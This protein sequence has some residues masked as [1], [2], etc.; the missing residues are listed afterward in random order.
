MAT[1]EARSMLLSCFYLWSSSNKCWPPGENEGFLKE[2]FNE[3]R[4]EILFFEAVA[5]D[6]CGERQLM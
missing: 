4:M 2:R 3:G 1:K 6:K 5:L